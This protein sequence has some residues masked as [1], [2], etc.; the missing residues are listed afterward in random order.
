MSKPG[1]DV[2]LKALIMDSL[3]ARSG[4][5]LDSMLINEIAHELIERMNEVVLD[6]KE[7]AINEI[8]Y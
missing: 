1:T 5:Q 7:E 3:I 6:A 2:M 8:I 4:K